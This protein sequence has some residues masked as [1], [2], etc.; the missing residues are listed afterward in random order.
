MNARV[1]HVCLAMTA[2]FYSV[3][4]A[5]EPQG[6]SGTANASDATGTSAESLRGC[7]DDADSLYIGDVADDTVKKF[8]AKTG[9]SAGTFV[10]V[11]DG[12]RGLL[13]GDRGNLVL[14]NQNPSQSY[15]GEV[16]KYD[17]H[18]GSLLGPI[19]SHTNPKAP[20]APRGIVRDGH[21]LYVADMGDA[22]YVVGGGPAPNPLPGR[23]AEFDERTGAWISDIAY[24]DF[25]EKCTGATCV[26]WSPRA[27]VFGPDDALYVSLMQFQ[28]NTD[29]NTLSGRV[30]RF[31]NHGRGPGSVFVD[32]DTC[33]CDLARPEGL[34][35]GPD[36]KLYVTSFRKNASDNDKILVFNG[37]NG[38]YQDKIDLDVVGGDRAFAQAIVFGP[39]GKL[40]VPISGN[41]AD[42]GSVRRY[43]VNS[44]TYDVFIAAGGS[45]IAPWYLT[46][47]KTDPATLAY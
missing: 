34:T 31:G 16:F 21:H 40:Y 42:S 25:G 30:V 47:G 37:R 22:D 13:F 39:K 2:A 26:Q 33:G 15:S 18:N 45:L 35:F 32:G 44:K 10:S 46:F 9:A 3:G 29:P 19:V 14:V 7:D 1:L 20:F 5:S 38:H 11:A 41:G 6:D 27:L 43:N 36:N 12:P 8:D 4:C 17:G 28:G 24:S 23:V